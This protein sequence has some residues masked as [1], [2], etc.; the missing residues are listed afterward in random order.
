MTALNTMMEMETERWW[1]TF[2]MET[3]RWWE[4]FL[5]M[6]YLLPAFANPKAT[7]IAQP[8]RRRQDGKWQPLRA[9]VKKKE[10]V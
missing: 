5:C 4:I 1:R 7:T 10:E 9:Y 3:E 6:H 2:L 8:Q